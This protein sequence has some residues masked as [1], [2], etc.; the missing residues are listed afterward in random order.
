MAHHQSDTDRILYALKVVEN[1]GN[2]ILGLLKPKYGH[3]DVHVIQVGVN[4]MPPAVDHSPDFVLN[5]SDDFAVLA[6]VGPKLPSGGY[7][8]SVTWSTSD[9]S[10]PLVQIPDD[11]QRDADGNPVLD[12]A[13]NQIPVFKTQVNT[14]GDSGNVTITVSSAQMANC[15]IHVIWNTPPVGHFAIQPSELPE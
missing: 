5:S 6:V 14:P 10:N 9:P 11:I 13:G 8:P 15:D 2:E 1:Q 12:D 4:N 7:V 3:F